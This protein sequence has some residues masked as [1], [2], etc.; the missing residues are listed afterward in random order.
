VARSH[1]SFNNP[2]IEL[3]H[4]LFNN[5][6]RPLIVIDVGAAVGDTVFLLHSNL[7]GAFGKILCI[8]GDREFFNYLKQNMQQFTFV[9]CENALLSS[10]G[11]EERSLVRIHA[12]TASSQGDNVVQSTTLDRLLSDKKIGH[13]DLLKIDTDG[14]DGKVLAGAKEI[15][16]QSKPPVIFEWHPILIQKTGNNVNE[17]FKI[18]AEFGYDQFLF[19]TKYGVFSHFMTGCNTREI[20][21]LSQ[22][23]INGRH[24]EDWHYDVI[25]VPNNSVNV[26]AL[27]EASFA[28][29]KKSIC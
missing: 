4:Q 11:G 26:V 3:A 22:V 10:Q 7:P 29:R 18:L 15:L 20:G 25:A 17:P 5:K 12:G 16:T 19:Y 27:A 14:F 24:D 23:C 6:G 28:K 13:V 2:L 21:L 8:D 1:K 9:D